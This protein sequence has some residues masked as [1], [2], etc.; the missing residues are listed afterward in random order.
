MMCSMLY[1]LESLLI[2]SL[3]NGQTIFPQPRIEGQVGDTIIITCE[4]L[5]ANQGVN[6]ALQIFRSS[7][8]EFADFLISPEAMGRIT[9]NDVDDR[10]TNY[11]F[12]P[13]RSEDNG[14]VLQCFNSGVS[15]NSSVITVNFEA[16]IE[17]VSPQGDP[18]VGREGQT[19]TIQL[20]VSANPVP[21]FTWTLNGVVL[22][23]SNR[24]T[25]EL[26]YIQFD[27]LQK[28][29]SG[30]YKLEA[31]NIIGTTNYTFVLDVQYPPTFANNFVD[32]PNSNCTSRMIGKYV[33][34]SV[35]G[36][37]ISFICNATG[38][39]LPEITTVPAQLQLINSNI[40]I[41][42]VSSNSAGNYTC[43]AA[44]TGFQSQTRQFTL[45]VGGLP[46]PLVENDLAIE[47]D[48]VR[49][50][51]VVTWSYNDNMNGVPASHFIV[52]IIEADTTTEVIIAEVLADSS[53][54]TISFAQLM[55][56]RRYTAT[57]AVRNMQ[58][59]S[60]A[61]AF[62]FKTPERS[63]S[64]AASASYLASVLLVLV[65]MMLLH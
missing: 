9:R 51:V 2:I 15:G 7:T 24:V 33:C 35:A 58:G 38:N 45:F 19:L 64:I 39:P 55:L 10:N 6:N 30:V 25:V 44:A 23:S 57:V 46:G 37:P 48:D 8:Q 22:P 36:V 43:T 14:I 27:S 32:P 13:L 63:S 65:A 60:V 11:T 50:V 3:S 41:N 49:Q 20:N 53:S 56:G 16:I 18:V 40:V 28:N 47:V 59:N 31:T 5:R 4:S 62:T 54:F 21:T 17:R 52:R 1:L 34:A 42:S 12:G 26:A 61:R 29:D